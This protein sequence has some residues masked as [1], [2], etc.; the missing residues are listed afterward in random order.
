MSDPSASSLPDGEK[1]ETTGP[2]QLAGFAGLIVAVA[3]IGI[4][5]FAFAARPPIT[6]GCSPTVPPLPP[7]PVVGVVVF[8]DSSSLGTVDSFTLRLADGSAAVLPMGTLENAADFPP[9]H[10]AEHQATAS[11]VR[12]F[13]R[14]D[15]SGIPS[16][17]R[18]EDAGG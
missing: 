8:V 3:V 16:V 18:L 10:L 1:R 14:L 17:Y 4:A 13:Y 7:S 9:G 2:R 12:A 11:P 15:A 6:C 5:A